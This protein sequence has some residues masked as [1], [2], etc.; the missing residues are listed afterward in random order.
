[1]SLTRLIAAAKAW[2]APALRR[3]LAA[4]ASLADRADR[5]GRAAL[6]YLC[7]AAPLA[8]RR[9]S[10]AISA[11]HA[12]LAGGADV[13]RVR[14]IRDGTEIFPGTPLWHAVA[15]GRNAALARFLIARGARPAHCLW[16]AVYN[17]DVVMLRVLLNAGAPLEE[18]FHD[19]TPLIYAVSLRRWQCVDVLAR[20]GADTSARNA[21]G[22]TPLD[23]AHRRRFRSDERARLEAI[24]GDSGRRRRPSG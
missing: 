18:R 10:R 9:A 1:V 21:R 3:L 24:A 2:D 16:A 17:D 6:H 7:A 22:E 5:S 23:I 11:A 8:G 14:P 19:E 4:D 13:N 15:W 12:L 20:A